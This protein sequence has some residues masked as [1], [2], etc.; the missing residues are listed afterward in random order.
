MKK[1]LKKYLDK[2]KEEFSYLDMFLEIL[3]KPY[4]EIGVNVEKQHHL[5]IDKIIELCDNVQLNYNTKISSISIYVNGDLFFGVNDFYDVYEFDLFKT[6]DI[7][8]LKNINKLDGNGI[9]LNICFFKDFKIKDN[10]LYM[11]DGNNI[12]IE[13]FI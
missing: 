9:T 10:V 1:E 3:R 7:L 6:Y 5:D 12:D 11:C 2:V 4:F 8:R 13:K